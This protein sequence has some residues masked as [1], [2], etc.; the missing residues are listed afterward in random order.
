MRTLLISDAEDQHGEGIHDLLDYREQRHYSNINA[1]DETDHYH[2]DSS[3][4]DE[5]NYSTIEDFGDQYESYGHEHSND[6][7]NYDM[8]RQRELQESTSEEQIVHTAVG[9]RTHPGP[10]R[11]S[12]YD[13][14]S[15]QIIHTAVDNRTHPG[16]QRKS[17][18]DVSSDQI[19]HTAVDNKTQPGPQ[20]K[21]SYDA[22]NDQIIHT[23]SN[24]RDY[25]GPQGK[26]SYDRN[27]DQMIHA[28][29]ETKEYS[30]PQRKS[31]QEE[32]LNTSSDRSISGYN[33]PRLNEGSV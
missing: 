19:I 16:P 24:M 6:Q 15:D 13:V 30:G 18:Y 31:S 5:I 17:S 20:R 22:S 14:S 3:S 29:T 25:S 27:N 9:N 23:A 12:R 11:K 8:A 32:S 21:S 33:P 4:K 7:G 10:Q 1:R 26:S 2:Q 28:A